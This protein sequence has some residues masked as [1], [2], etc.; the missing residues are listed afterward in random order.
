MRNL[1]IDLSGRYRHVIV[2]GPAALES[3]DAVD[4]ASQVGASILVDLIPQTAP[5]ELREVKG[6][7]G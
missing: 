7:F 5:E 2:V 6:Y 3:T 1:L 4:M